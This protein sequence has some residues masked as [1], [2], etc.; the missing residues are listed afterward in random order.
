MIHPAVTIDRARRRVTVAGEAVVTVHFEKHVR[1]HLVAIFGEEA[2]G[3]VAR[4]EDPATGAIVWEM[5]RRVASPPPGKHETT[6]HDK[7]DLPF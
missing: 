5:P 2:V 6:K 3:Y 4:R 7:G 1:P